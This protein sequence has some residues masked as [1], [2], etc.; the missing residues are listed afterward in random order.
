MRQ[1]TFFDN[2]RFHFFLVPFF[3]ALAG[4]AMLY[5]CGQEQK[6]QQ[7]ASPIT[8]ENLQTAYAK[9]LKYSA[10]YA[11]FAA[12]AEKERLKEAANLYR[13]VAR[14]EELHAARH[15]DLLRAHGI[16]PRTPALDSLTIGTTVQ[17]LKMALSSEEIEIESMYSNLIRTAELEKFTEAVNQFEKIKSSDGRQ[18]DL[19]K[20]ALDKNAKITKVPYFVC[21]GCGYILTSDKTDECP[22]CHSGKGQFEKLSA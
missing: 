8:L 22:N 20:E 16:E 21:P 4:I 15:A 19:L 5:G 2:V 7:Q 17:S 12:N 13:A 3:A 6:P 1:M 10:M 9:S 11:R 14:S 18:N